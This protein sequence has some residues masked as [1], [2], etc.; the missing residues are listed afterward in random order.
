[1]LVLSM[2]LK[3]IQPTL[4]CSEIRLY[5]HKFQI[6]LT[7]CSV[8]LMLLEQFVDYKLFGF[9]RQEKPWSRVYETAV[10]PYESE[11]S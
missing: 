5:M 2:F 8:I 11:K 3:F 10:G 6:S 1:M 7:K 4:Y 9:L